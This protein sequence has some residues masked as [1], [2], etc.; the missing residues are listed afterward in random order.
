MNKALQEYT[1][2]FHIQGNFDAEEGTK[3]FLSKVAFHHYDYAVSQFRKR[4]N[5]LKVGTVCV[6]I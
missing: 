6:S 3:P 2:C 5:Q 1:K 4:L